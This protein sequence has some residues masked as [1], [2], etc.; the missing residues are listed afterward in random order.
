MKT[1]QDANVEDTEQIAANNR[2]HLN[3]C[4]KATG[5]RHTKGKF[6]KKNKDKKNPISM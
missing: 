1:K 6:A 2:T 3:I 5:S 4:Q